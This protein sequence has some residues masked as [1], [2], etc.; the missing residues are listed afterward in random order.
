MP[1]LRAIKCQQDLN[2]YRFF[3]RVIVIDPPAYVPAKAHFL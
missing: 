2:G 1:N 3:L